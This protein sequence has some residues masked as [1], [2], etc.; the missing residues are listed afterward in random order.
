LPETDTAPQSSK[1]KALV[2]LATVS[3]ETDTSL[4]TPDP[5]TVL[6]TVA[7]LPTHTVLS[8][9]LGP[10]RLQVVARETP[11]PDPSTVTLAAPLVGALT[12]TCADTVWMLNEKDVASVDHGT[13][14]TVPTKST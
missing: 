10:T 5:T 11:R 3:A 13:T 8:V 7:V 1:D 6:Q 9:S 12:E 2:R 14:A 4:L